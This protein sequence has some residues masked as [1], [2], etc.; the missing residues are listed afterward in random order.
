MHLAFHQPAIVGL[1]LV[2]CVFSTAN[3][4]NPAVQTGLAEPTVIEGD[5]LVG[6]RQFGDRITTRGVSRASEAL[7]PDGI[8]HYQIDP[9]LAAY[10]VAFIED[11]IETWNTVTAISIVPLTVD[12]MDDVENYIYFKPG[13]GCASWVGMQGGRQDIWVAPNCSTGSM[14]HEIGHAIGL[15]HEHTRPDRDQYIQ[16]NW[17]NVNPSKLQ[18]FGTAPQH[19][20][21]LGEYDYESIMHYGA[22]FFSENGHA[23]IVPLFAD[24][25]VIGQRNAPSEGDIKSIGRMYFGADDNGIVQIPTANISNSNGYQSQASVGKLYADQGASENAGAGSYSLLL[26]LLYWVLQL[27]RVKQNHARSGRH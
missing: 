25:S 17:E 27:H 26:L 11:A 6:E 10:S 4:A 1:L 13:V 12:A 8:I 7:W 5:I 15:E 16:I 21:M 3:A 18:N 22:Q 20:R 23:T 19:L 9:E 14:M 2:G 24:P